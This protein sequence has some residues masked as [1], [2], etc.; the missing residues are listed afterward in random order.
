VLVHAGGHHRLE[1]SDV[2]KRGCPRQVTAA[3]NLN[4]LF[5][6]GRSVMPPGVLSPELL[7]RDVEGFVHTRQAGQL[8][9]RQVAQHQ[10]VC[11]RRES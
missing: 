11:L 2:T 4:E 8:H 3:L 9:G 7:P 5:C 6:S 10:G 1:H